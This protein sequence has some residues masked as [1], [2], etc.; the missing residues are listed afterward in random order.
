MHA[1]WPANL[2]LLDFIT[3]IIFSEKY[4]LPHLPHTELIQV[5]C[6]FLL[7]FSILLCFLKPI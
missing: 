5:P 2:I 4:H 6:I 3:L 1:I 7:Y